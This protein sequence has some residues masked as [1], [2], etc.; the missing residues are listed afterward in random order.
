MLDAATLARQGTFWVRVD[1]TDP[2]GATTSAW[3]SGPVETGTPV[4][5][6]DVDPH[7]AFMADV[8]WAVKGG[9]ADGY[10][11]DTFGPGDAVSRQ[12]MAAFLRRLLGPATLPPCSERPAPDITVSHPFCE[13]ITWLLDSGIAEGFPDGRFYPTRP[14]SRQAMAAF[15]RRAA[16]DG[17]VADCTTAPFSDVDPTGSF[18]GAI[19]WLAATG[20]SGGFADGTY[21]PSSAVSRQQ[22]TRFLHL[23]E[24][25]GL[26]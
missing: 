23:L 15:L 8:V 26:T 14:V 9:V 25:N 21:R 20:I 10:D 11:P 12:A 16:V 18:C 5:F 19:S 2:A 24:D 1:V 7:G 17:P 4:E 6:M 22:M 3:S 13:D